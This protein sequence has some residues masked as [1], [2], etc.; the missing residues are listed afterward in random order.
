MNMHTRRAASRLCR[1]F[2]TGLVL[3]AAL[4]GLG[5]WSPY[6]PLREGGGGAAPSGGTASQGLQLQGI[7]ISPQPVVTTA[8][9][10]LDVTGGSG[11]LTYAWSVGGIA[12]GAVGSSAA[13]TSPGMPGIVQV[14]VTVSDGTTPVSGTRAMTVTSASP[15][16]KFKGNLQ[17]TG[18]GT[19]ASG[20]VGTKKWSYAIFNSSSSS[21][22]VGADGTIYV[23]S[24]DGYIY[25]FNPVGTRKWRYNIGGTIY[26]SSPA[27]GADGTV[28]L[29]CGN[30]LYA[31]NPNGTM[32]WRVITGAVIYSSPTIAADG[33]IYI[34]SD[35][36]F[37]W[38]IKP[39]GTTKW[40]YLT[41]GDIDSSPA[42]GADGTIYF[43]CNNNKLYALKTDGTLKW[44]FTTG[45]WV[46]SSPAI[47]AD[48]TIY[49]GS[50]DK[51]RKSVV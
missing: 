12:L 2:A 17:G 30:C 5:C 33:T 47:G 19:V 16:A 14:G 35:D 18:A 42:I 21:A 28:Y 10:G 48:G 46:W 38:A 22:A 27:I 25:A 29:G 34:G 13:W 39:N 7:T 23:G 32:K 51:D 49:A 44:S 6:L 11:P 43:G 50:K 40:K 1:I 8:T 3:A 31:M 15:W 26:D 41:N 9:L 24:Y 20:A 45:G 4:G 36:C 37:L